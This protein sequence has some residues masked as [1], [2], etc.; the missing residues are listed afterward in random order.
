[1]MPISTHVQLSPDNADIGGGRAGTVIADKKVLVKMFGE[2]QPVNS[3]D[4]KVTMR[5]VFKTPKGYASVRDYWWNGPAEWS[6][7]GATG[8]AVL[9]L[10][11]YLRSLGLTAGRLSN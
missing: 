3:A 6:I 11:R 1:M 9:Y 10:F 4:G 5:W 2:P 7:D 8:K